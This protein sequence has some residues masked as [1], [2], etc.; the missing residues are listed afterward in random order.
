MTETH[1]HDPIGDLALF[2]T[3]S[4]RKRY[5]EEDAYGR[6]KMIEL[7]MKLIREEFNEV[8]DEFLDTLNGVGNYAKLAKELADLKYVVYGT[9]YLLDIPAYAVWDEVQRSNMSKFGPNGEIT[10]NAEGKI[11]KGPNYSAAD[12]EGVL[13]R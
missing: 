9:E 1:H 7:R 2:E 8:M 13:A 6:K 10:R 3:C 5:I 4:E 12:I 11:L